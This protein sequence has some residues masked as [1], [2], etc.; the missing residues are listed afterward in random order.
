MRHFRASLAVAALPGGMPGSPAE[1]ALIARAGATHGLPSRQPRA[2]PA[3]V[4]IAVIAALADRDL[5]S[6][7][8]AVI[9]P[10]RRLLEPQ[11]PLPESLDSVGAARH[12]ELAKPPAVALCTEGPGC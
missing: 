11:D 8:A 7:A 6:A 12:K 4:E 9:E 1:G 5:H 3:A 2:L 10:V